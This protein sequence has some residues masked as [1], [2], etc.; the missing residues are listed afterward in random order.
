MKGLLPAVVLEN[1]KYPKNV[2]N[3]LRACYNL[4]VAQLAFTGSRVPLTPYVGYRLPREERF[5]QFTD[6]VDIINV[7]RPLDL[8]PQ[9]TP[10]VAIEILPG[11]ENL[12]TF[13]HPENAVYVFG[14]EDGDVSKALR[15]RCHR[16]VFIPTKSCLNLASAVTVVLYDRLL[17]AVQKA[18]ESGEAP[19]AMEDIIERFSATM[20]EVDDE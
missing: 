3:V 17:K 8:Y 14:P 10:I 9:G 2:G 5:K 13:E 6:A 4:G 11:A 15:V 18:T 19:G 20:P 7:G 16:F 1:P 12:V